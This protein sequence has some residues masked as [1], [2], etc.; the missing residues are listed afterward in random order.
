MALRSGESVVALVEDSSPV[1]SGT[2]RSTGAAP[3][4]SFHFMLWHVC[5]RSD[6]IVPEIGAQLG[7]VALSFALLGLCLAEHA[8]ELSAVVAAAV[9]VVGDLRARSCNA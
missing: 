9:L 6:L 5:I 2:R 8:L 1:S 3:P 4:I 7:A